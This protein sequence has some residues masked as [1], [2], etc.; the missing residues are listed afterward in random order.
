V[1][2]WTFLKKDILDFE[3][4]IEVYNENE[5]EYDSVKL[6]EEAVEKIVHLKDLCDEY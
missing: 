4:F 3:F 1:A 2:L 5:G 6:D